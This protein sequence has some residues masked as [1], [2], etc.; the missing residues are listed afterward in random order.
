MKAM[1]AKRMAAGMP[2]GGHS[3]S[4]SGC[5]HCQKSLVTV[6]SMLLLLLSSFVCFGGVIVL[7]GVGV[8]AVDVAVAVAVVVVAAAVVLDG[9]D[10]VDDVVV[11]DVV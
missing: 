5:R 11:V 7:I 9:V 4:P 1:K 3:T 6:L 8:V 10:D 2:W